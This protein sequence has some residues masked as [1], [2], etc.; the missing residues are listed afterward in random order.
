MEGVYDIDYGGQVVGAAK[1]A[2]EG[3]YYRFECRCRVEGLCRL[4]VCCGGHHENLGIPVPAGSEFVLTTKIPVKRLGEG[5]LQILA[6]PKNQRQ[7]GEFI[8][9]YPEEPFAYISRLQNA[10]LQ[11]RDGQI[12]VVFTP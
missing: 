9:V 6:L 8:P 12:G 5:P 1:V 4:S 3:L 2:R 7:T 10:F 11:V